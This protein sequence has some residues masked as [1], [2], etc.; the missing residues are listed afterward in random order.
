MSIRE[1]KNKILA[2]KK[3]HPQKGALGTKIKQAILIRL[4][5][6]HICFVYRFHKHNLNSEQTS[7]ILDWK[8]Y[9]YLKR[10]YSRFFAKLTLPSMPEKQTI[11]KIIWWCWLQGEENAPSLCRA[12]LNSLR[13]NMS[14]YEIR[15]VTEENMWDLI[16]VP[17]FIRNKYE[18]GIIPRTQFSDLLRTCLLIEH[19]GIWLDSTVLCTGNI[20]PAQFDK[21]LFI[22]QNYKRGDESMCLSTWLIA[23]CSNEPG[24]V[25]TRE[26][27]FEYWR[28]NNSLCHYFIYH[29]FFTMVCE[30]YP[31]I[32]KSVPRY[33]N[34]PPH[35][36]QFEMFEKFNE[37]RWQQIKGMSAFHKLS[38]KYDTELIDVR[39][40]Y[41][42]HILQEYG[43]KCI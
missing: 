29:F 6:F 8:W 2:Y 4:R 20:P 40:S 5:N 42:E 11:P 13:K 1:M 34:L 43:E 24:L 35:I 41:Y 31:E 36:L 12:C 10:K 18:K 21:H 22:Y 3:S 7:R 23:S 17:D 33:S 27:L 32:L 30:K 39:N 19:G 9:V 16:S 15:I 14:D 37:T 26:L 38:W 25:L 28:R